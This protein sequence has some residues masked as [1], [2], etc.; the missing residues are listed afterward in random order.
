MER[1]QY[2]G[3]RRSFGRLDDLIPTLM[4]KAGNSDPFCT[5]VSY[6]FHSVL[7]GCLHA[8]TAV[9]SAKLSGTAERI[10]VSRSIRARSRSLLVSCVGDRGSIDEGR[11]ERTGFRLEGLFFVCRTATGRN[12][13]HFGH[14]SRIN[15]AGGTRVAARK[16]RARLE[17]IALLMIFRPCNYSGRDGASIYRHFGNYSPN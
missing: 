1:K 11:D 3:R 12:F 2:R 15:L 7:D 14:S 6:R 8:E 10:L 16:F 17:D 13:F 5:C 4:P 9:Q